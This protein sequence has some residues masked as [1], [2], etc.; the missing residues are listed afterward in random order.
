MKNKAIPLTGTARWQQFSFED[1]LDSRDE[2][3]E[4]L[5]N[6]FRSRHQATPQ[7]DRFFK[8]L[9]RAISYGLFTQNLPQYTRAEIAEKLESISLQDLTPNAQSK[10]GKEAK[11]NAINR[12]VNCM[13]PPL[14]GWLYSSDIALYQAESF[15]DVAKALRKLKLKARVELNGQGRTHN[16]IPTLLAADIAEALIEIGIKPKAGSKPTDTNLKPSIYFSIVQECFSLVGIPLLDP[17]IHMRK[18]LILIKA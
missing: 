1:H 9:E 15:H 18:A 5:N 14:K 2:I 12:I 3:E 7:F 13:P 16:Q 6:Y 8:S 11:A 17:S 10:S 4:S